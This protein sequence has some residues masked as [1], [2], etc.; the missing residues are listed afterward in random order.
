MIREN[1]MPRQGDLVLTP[2][3]LLAFGRRLPCTFGQGG[4]RTNKREGD[5]ATPVG[6]HRI[7]GLYFRPDRMTPPVPW[8]LMPGQMIM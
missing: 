4:I 8:A 1:P 5:G 7:V 3:G 6:V 2:T